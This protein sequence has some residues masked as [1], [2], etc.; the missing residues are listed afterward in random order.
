MEHKLKT[1]PE[2]FEAVVNGRK[3]FE[4]R[5]DDRPFADGDTLL[6][7]EWDGSRYTGRTI[8]ASVGYVLRGEYCRDGYCVMGIKLDGTN[9]DRFRAMSDEE[10]AAILV[11]EPMA[12]K[13]PFCQNSPE[14]DRL[15]ETDRDIPEEMCAKCALDWLRQ[16]A[17]EE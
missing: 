4:V 12:E 9:A 2:Y 6:L 14:C 7:E 13:I 11:A 15:M 5:R 10:L 8:K 1:L 16:P 3:T 17:K